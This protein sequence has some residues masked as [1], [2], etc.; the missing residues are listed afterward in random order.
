MSTTASA[1]S[2]GDDESQSTAADVGRTNCSKSFAAPSASGGI[3]SL[4]SDWA[5]SDFRRALETAN[6]IV[7]AVLKHNAGLPF[8]NDDD[9]FIPLYCVDD[10]NREDDRWC[11][12][13][14]SSIAPSSTT[15]AHIEPRLRERWFGDWDG[16][17]DAHYHNVWNQDA[18]DP[19]HTQNTVE[20]VWSVLDRATRMK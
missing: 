6:A 15:I 17:S 12:T 13:P 9:D 1:R 11:G 8:G 5:T 18:L 19:Y 14:R 4:A 2:S 20:S 16:T 10:H 7:D 3:R